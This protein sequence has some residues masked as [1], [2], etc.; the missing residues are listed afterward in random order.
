MLGT[1]NLKIKYVRFGIKLNFFLI[2]SLTDIVFIKDVIFTFDDH[3]Y[4]II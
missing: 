1:P 4:I 2:F 3:I